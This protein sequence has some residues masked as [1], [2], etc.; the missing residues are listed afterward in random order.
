[1]HYKIVTYH[2]NGRMVMTS[3]FICPQI[4]HTTKLIAC[5]KRSLNFSALDHMFDSTLHV[6]V[7]HLFHHTIKYLFL[8]GVSNFLTNKD[9]SAVIKK[10]NT[11]SYRLGEEIIKVS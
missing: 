11:Y 3:E 1:M 5:D 9:F 2:N 4:E 10:T 6:F 7:H 8:M